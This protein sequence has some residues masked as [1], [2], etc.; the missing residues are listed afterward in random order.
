M[1]DK[2]YIEKGQK[3]IFFDTQKYLE[4][5]ALNTVKED[6]VG[7]LKPYFMISANYYRLTEIV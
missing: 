7:N 1:Y 6:T 3:D 4:G 5:Y 2:G